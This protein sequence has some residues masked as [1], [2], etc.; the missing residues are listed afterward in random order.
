MVDAE[1][2]KLPEGIKDP[3]AEF[4]LHDNLGKG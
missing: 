4:D 1:E 3:A 2:F